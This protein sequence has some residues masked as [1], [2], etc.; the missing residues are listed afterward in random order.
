MPP[1]PEWDVLL[2]LAAPPYIRD[3]TTTALSLLHAMLRQGARVQTWACGSA[4]LLTQQS[5]GRLKP[6][7]LRRPSARA[8]TTAAL[9]ADLLA[10]HGDR[11]R[12]SACRFCSQDRG[13][14]HIPEVQVRSPL[15]LGG[16]L[17][18]SAK[19]I[20]IGGF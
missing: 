7:D 18:A 2:F 11:T 19:T 16:Y 6:P 15:R 14:T 10:E 9:V 12:W 4:T 3:T 13:A 20:Y 17:R 5:L 1:R 8:P